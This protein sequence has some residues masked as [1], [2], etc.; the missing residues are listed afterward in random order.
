MINMIEQ[1]IELPSIDRLIASNISD[2]MSISVILWVIKNLNNELNESKADYELSL[3]KVQH[4]SEYP[5]IFVNFLGKPRGIDEE[6]IA[7]GDAFVEKA[8]FTDFLI[9]VER[10]REFILGEIKKYN[11]MFDA[12]S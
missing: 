11:E 9:F 3:I 8:L 12:S 2:E 6:V 1:I 10:E 7:K 5:A 4:I